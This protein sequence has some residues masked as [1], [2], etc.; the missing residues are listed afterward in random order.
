MATPKHPLKPLWVG[1]RGLPAQFPENTLSS[2][3]AAC[4]AGAQGVEFDVQMTQDGVPVLLHDADL[5][6]MSGDSRAIAECTWKALQSLSAAEPERFGTRYQSEPFAALTEV[7]EKLTCWPEVTVFVELKR[8]SLARVD[9]EVYVRSVCD[10]LAPI[11]AQCVVISY[12]LS[13]LRIAQ[14][15]FDIRVGWVLT[16]YTESEPQALLN[17]PVDFVICNYKKLPARNMALWQGP[18]EW[19]VYDVMD[20]VTKNACLQ[21]GVRWLETWDVALAQSW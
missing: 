4:E 15:H 14:S 21:R 18:W 1:H 8:E 5:M 17:Q 20:P 12:D 19:F 11:W 10:A 13:L 3:L 16:H 9:A 2:V 7:A 6:R